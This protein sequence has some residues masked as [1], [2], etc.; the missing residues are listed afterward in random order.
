MQFMVSDMQVVTLSSDHFSLNYIGKQ[1][2]N[3]DHAFYV[4]PYDTEIIALI[5]QYFD[6]L[7]P[8]MS[9]YD[10]PAE[11]QFV[12]YYAPAQSPHE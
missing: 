5:H 8:Q 9:P 10:L 2:M 6:V 11:H 4:D 1:K 7:P 12:L 3:R